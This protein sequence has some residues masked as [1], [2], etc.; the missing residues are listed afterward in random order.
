[1]NRFPLWIDPFGVI[2]RALTL[3]C[4]DTFAS[5]IPRPLRF[6]R[7]F[8]LL[9]SRL[10]IPAATTPSRHF[11]TFGFDPLGTKIAWT[12]PVAVFRFP[13]R[14]APT[15]A[16]EFLKL[17]LIGFFPRVQRLLIWHIS[18]I[19]LAKLDLP[20]NPLDTH[21]VDF[22]PAPIREVAPVFLSSTPPPIYLH[23]Q[24]SL[25]LPPLGCSPPKKRP[26]VCTPPPQPHH[27]CEEAFSTPPFFYPTTHKWF[28]LLPRTPLLFLQATFCGLL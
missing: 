28:G 5:P 8:P 10:L 24:P 3:G 27:V 13:R 26:Y 19:R 15:F 2:A 1:L 6:S 14:P 11:L 25:V 9:R 12:E 23:L 18:Q 7:F 17:F 4:P 22:L 20:L 16:A 21:S